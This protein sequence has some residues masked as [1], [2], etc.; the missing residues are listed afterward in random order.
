MIGVASILVLGIA[1]EW[2][3]WRIHLPS[4]LLLLV[5][6]FLAGPVTGFLRP[7]EML[8]ELLFPIVS[9][10]VA[11]ILFEGGLSLRLSELR[12]IGGVV[13][14]LVTVGVLVTWI[15]IALSAHLLVGVPLSLGILTGAILVVTGPTV[16]VPLLR[17]LRL[18]G[19]VGPALR[20]EAMLNDPIGAVLAVLVFETIVAGGFQ[21]APSVA[22]LGLLKAA[23]IG[24]VMAAIGAGALIQM[25]KRR[26]VPDFLHS[27]VA[28][29]AVVTA[30]TISNVF[31]SESGLLTATI[32]GVALA[33][34]K[35]VTIRHIAE[36]KENLQ[37]LLVSGLF[38]LLAARLELRDVAEIGGPELLFLAVALFLV[39][40]AAVALAT[41]GSGLDWR[42]RV[43]ISWVAP[44]GIVAAAVSSL[45]ALELSNIGYAGADHLV[46]LV[47][48]VIVGTVTLTGLTA[49][50]LAALL[51]VKS[52][53][54]QGMLIVGAHSW[55]RALAHTLKEEGY[56]IRVVDT[57]YANIAA[58][59]MAG[60][61]TYYG[62]AVT[63]YALDEIELQG[64]G[65]LL[66]LTPNDEVNSLTALHFADI[67]DR[68]EVYQL[69]PERAETTSRRA[70]SEHLRGR[71]LFDPRAT[72]RYLSARFAA[73]AVI[74][75]TKLTREFD[76]DSFREYYGNAI[77]LFLI[78]ENRSLNV[79]SVDNPPTPR[80][81]QTLIAI[82]D[83]L[84]EDT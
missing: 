27:P 75:K 21:E 84:D 74:K 32:M 20:W 31:Q 69:P 41:V 37:V 3:A 42:E 77:P 47:F 36:F 63:E 65:R 16:I 12:E 80:P 58:A 26:W 45:F 64:I 33:N 17:Q 66:A 7:D 68:T 60:L 15:L 83:P 55:A 24:I 28:L 39:R 4:I 61:P 44:R 59:R 79:F 40:P 11:I 78:S 35:S 76:Y 49:A 54:P 67:F 1:A 57:N 62:S 18:S 30:F 22:L 50:P 73:G 14:D 23:L 52:P 56:R 19:Q 8:G 46:E 10:S 9:I 13:R 53:N 72:Y 82:V 51:G 71:L 5:F 38:I 29:M 43:F 6:G 81:G 48:L 70:V 2:L 34:Q 25:L